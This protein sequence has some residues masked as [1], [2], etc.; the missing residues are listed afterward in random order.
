MSNYLKRVLSLLLTVF[1]LFGMMPTIITAVEDEE[2]VLSAPTGK[3]VQAAFRSG[4]GD[5]YSIN[6]ILSEPDWTLSANVGSSGMFGAVW[7]NQS[8]CIGV[9][10]P[11]NAAVAV[12]LNG[13]AIT[14][15]PATIRRTEKHVEY[16]I[17]HRMINSSRADYGCQISATIQIGSEVWIGTIVLS[18]TTWFAA[19]TPTLRLANDGW[20]VSQSALVDMDGGRNGHQG[21]KSID[22]GYN[23]YD[24]YN[25]NGTNPRAIR[26]FMLYRGDYLRPLGDRTLDTVFEYTFRANAMPVYELGYDNEFWSYMATAGFM[27]WMTDAANQAASMG[28][29]NTDIGLVFV[30]QDPAGYQ[31]FPL[32]KH[33]GDTFRVGTAWQP[34]GDII[35]YIDGAPVTVFKNIEIVPRIGETLDP[36][37]IVLNI[38]RSVDRAESEADNISVDITNIAIG[39]AYGN[40]VIDSV[41]FDMICGKNTD[42]GAVIYDL[43]LPAKFKNPQIDIPYDITW[44]SSDPD[45]I[46]PAS[47]TVKRPAA[48]GK[49]VTLTA[50]IDELGVSKKFNLY[51]KGMNPTADTL[52]V[53]KDIDTLHGAG[54]PYDASTFTLDATN[55]SVVRDLGERK[56]VNVIALKDSDAITRLNESMLTVWA[57]DDNRS[58]REVD[59]FKLLRAGAVTYLYDFTATG[60]YIKVHATT[61][62]TEA[63]DFIAPL[64]GMIDVYYENEFGNGGADFA[65]TTFITLQNTASY[66]VYDSVYAISPDTAGINCAL[67]SKADIR[68]YLG[69]ELLYHTYDGNN[70][71]V[72]VPKIAANATITVSALSGNTEAMDISNTEA[73]YEVVYGTRETYNGGGGQFHMSLPDGTLVHFNGTAVTQGSIAARFSYDEGRTWSDTVIGDGSYDY[74]CIP[75]GEAYDDVTGRILIQGWTRPK[76]DDGTYDEMHTVTRFMYSDDMGTTWHRAPITI[77]GQDMPHYL[78]YSDI[79]KV[80][81]YDGEDGPNVD[82]LTILS[83]DDVSQTD[84]E[85]DYPRAAARC[86]YTT[87]G[88]KSWTTSESVIRYPKGVGHY[89]RETG[90]CET[91]VLEG[92]DGTLAMYARCQYENVDHFGVS[93]SYDHGLTWTEEA[94]LSNVYATNTQPFLFEFDNAKMLMWAGNNA[95]GGGSYRRFPINIAIS[96]DNLKTFV[97]IQDIYSR[98]PFQGML[99]GTLV[100]GVNPTISQVGDSVYLYCGSYIYSMRIDNFADYFYRTKGA[101]DSFESSPTKYE[102]WESNGGYTELS[103]DHATSGVNSMKFGVGSSSVRSIPSVSNGTIS[104]DLWFDDAA[105]ADIT[106]ELESS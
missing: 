104:F 59:D 88:G 22:F 31:S 79:I 84:W 50:T 61:H 15:S 100:D 94:V 105:T 89:V 85:G 20:N 70:F 78:A 12:T 27:Y 54:V 26:T 28:I 45:V 11:N 83:G 10:N 5:S 86:F 87:D 91:T 106:V 34:D 55:N 67:A 57:S 60:R 21:V 2:I 30:A 64:D 6:G 68:F 17:P 56:T 16:G 39:K 3:C 41:T 4:S 98:T 32:N 29:I 53:I 52:V 101:Y 36:T 25:P 49:D 9:Y 93:Y 69:D 74:V 103:S 58:Y 18:S 35:L 63:S 48:G 72:R 99:Q 44:T 51:V 42:P 76:L 102:G 43:V 65:N 46:D 81:S 66:T 92:E 77:I 96:Y 73:V 97:G 23:F 95:L 24:N 80:S 1:M 38:M 13:V 47:G 82:F 19:E 8:V 75:Q 33:I 14:G 90:I 37:A 62:D 40:S 71:L 7:D